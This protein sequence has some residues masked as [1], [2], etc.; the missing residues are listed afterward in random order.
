MIEARFWCLR[1]RLSG[2]VKACLRQPRLTHLDLGYIL[3]CSN[4][5]HSLSS[6]LGIHYQ[7]TNKLGDA[8]IFLVGI[9]MCLQVQRPCIVAIAE[10]SVFSH[11]CRFHYSVRSFTYIY[12]ILLL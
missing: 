5:T 2:L 11:N 7:L 12:Y 8:Y 3:T 1:C 6:M 9:W 4:N 10:Q